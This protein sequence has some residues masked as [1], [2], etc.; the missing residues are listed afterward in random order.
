MLASSCIWK[1]W[2]TS[3]GTHDVHFYASFALLDLFPK[4][5][6]SIQ[7]DFANAVLYEDR[8]KV[9][10]LADGTSGIR[11]AKGEVPHDLGTHDPCH[12]MNAYNI[13]DTSKWKDLNPKFVQQIYRDFA[14]TGD[15]SFGRDVWPAV[16]AAMDYMD[17][18]DRDGDGLI[19]NDGFPDQTYDEHMMPGPF[20]ESVLT[21][22]VFGLLHFKLQLQ[23]PIALGT[24]TSLKSTNSS[25]SKP[26]QYMR[27][28]Y[29]M[30]PISITTVAQV[31]IAYPS[32][33]ISWLDSGT[34]PRQACPHF[35]MSTRLKVPCRRYLSSM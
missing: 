18:F 17:Q 24:D 34:L 12:E 16:C 22:G 28:S 7:R 6:L 21:V 13:H 11:K 29:G 20:M 32:R 10:N 5:E 30:G 1:E 25:S 14:A 33:L 15:M 26:K 35:L 19:E 2:N 31:A 4:I 23:W 27:Q 8:R 9:K 3:C